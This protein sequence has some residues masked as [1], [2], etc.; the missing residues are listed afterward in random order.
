M[1]VTKPVTTAGLAWRGA[2]TGYRYLGLV[3][4]VVG[5]EDDARERGLVH[6]HAELLTEQHPEDLPAQHAGLEGQGHLV[7]APRDGGH[8]L[9]AGHEVV[10]VD[11]VAHDSEVRLA[12]L[13]DG[14]LGHA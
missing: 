1:P 3:L 13:R 11:V 12:Q 14:L 9:D 2:T 6:V 5:A 8:R 7:L 10:E 4:P